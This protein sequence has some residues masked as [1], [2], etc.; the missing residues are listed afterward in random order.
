MIPVGA[1][2]SL[3]PAAVAFPQVGSVTVT[4]DPSGHPIRSTAVPV[5]S[6]LGPV[7]VAH[8]GVTTP[9]AGAKLQSLLAVLALAVPHAVSDD[10]LLDE[11]WGDDQ[12]S[13][14]TNAMQALVSS[15][16]RLLGPGVVDRQG[17][18]YVLRVDPD[19]IDVNRFERLVGAARAAS[20]AGDHPAAVGRY[21]E[22]LALVRGDVLANLGDR[23]FARDASARLDELV[24]GAEEGLIDAELAVGHHAEVVT[25][26]LDLVRR[27]PLR[28]RFRAQLILAL[29][30]CDRQADALQ[31]YRDAREHL[32]D[33]LGLDPGP[34]LRALERAVLAQDPALA[35]PIAIASPLAQPSVLPVALTSLVGRERELE[36]IERA[37]RRD[38]LVTLVGPAGVGKSRLAVEIAHRVEPEREVW[39]VELATVVDAAAVALAV[40]AGVGARERP[41]GPDAPAPT[42]A[43]RVIDRLAGREVLVIVDNCEHVAE[44]AAAIVLDVLRGCGRVTVLATSR[45]PLHIDGELEVVVTPLDAERGSSLFL[46]RARTVQPLIGSGGRAEQEQIHAVVRDL[47]GLPLAIELAAAR[48]KTFPVGEIAE[49]LNDR[50][51]LLQGTRRGAASRHDGLGA[52]IGW[53]YDLL[54]DDERRAFRRLAICVGG[55]SVDAVERLCGTGSV[56]LA[57]RLVDRSLLTADTTGTAARF[58]ML[59]SL[60]AYGIARLADEGE[61]A[62]TRADHL[63]WCIELVDRADTHVTTADQLPWLQRLDAE[64]DNV[65]AALAYAVVDDPD[66]A[67]R[68]LGPLLRPWWFRGRRHDIATW[69]DAAL[70]ASAGTTT[71][72][73]ARV[74]SMSGLITEST[75]SGTDRVTARV[76]EDLAR[77][78]AR[79]REA[80]AFDETGH[81]R[82]AIAYDCLQLL[83]TMARRASIGGAVSPEE[84]AAWLA[85]GAAI[86]DELGDDYGSIVIRVTEAVLAIAQGDPARAAAHIA[87]AEPLADRLGE[88]FSRSRLEYVAGMLADLR[89]DPRAAYGHVERSLRLVDELGI[90][91]A[92][93]AQAEVLIP[94]ARRAGEAGL[95]TGWTSFVERSSPGAATFDGSVAAAGNNH[96]GL[97]ARGAGGYERA[98]EAHQLALAWYENAELPDGIAFSE[99]CL[100]FLAGERGDGDAARRHHAAALDAAIESGDDAALALALEGVATITAAREPARA[101][102]LLGAAASLWATLPTT[103]PTHRADVERATAEI[104]RDLGADAHDSSHRAGAELDRA[105]V[106]A[107]A[108]GR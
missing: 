38:R 81:D 78:E 24:L 70:A 13:K 105:G 87:V 50:F 95:A 58:R 63:A 3:M 28:E 61:L 107:A 10:R 2:A 60:R 57:A 97:A 37:L 73:R 68:L 98:A 14:P 19:E 9:V 40:A 21:R 48:T 75:S 44:A 22:A 16:R 18:G 34:E 65:C 23:W 77:A 20:S 32:R 12:P 1:E 33:E 49:R 8:D 52:A 41:A 106:L 96:L 89:G 35:A 29:Y 11:V 99:S 17:A 83:A 53:S 56:E 27:H 82:A 15:L 71:P 92:V 100:G 66:G 84:P 102:Q 94:L 47:D 36:G 69:S 80:L 88:R 26:V 5:V 103:I 55:A 30:R 101:A 43:E 62:A 45:E 86:F 104:R 59:E 46:E 25:T 42:P 85:R 6:L 51:T 67:L 7:A 108:R 31:A 91:H 76:H 4:I 79:Q 64:H 93:T 72:A 39:F 54:F 90:H 74:L